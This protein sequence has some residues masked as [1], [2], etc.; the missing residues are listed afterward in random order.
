MIHHVSFGTSDLKRARKFYDPV[1]QVLGLRLLREDE[2]SIDY[3]AS[4]I[5]FSLEVPVNGRTSSPGN[6]VHIA[7][8]AEDRNMVDEFY[9][10]ALKHGGKDDGPPGLRPKYDANYYGAFV[11]DPDGN[12]VEA[13]T[14]SAR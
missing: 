12:K 10:T 14:F 6:G 4:Y 11:L 2:S 13:V 5:L 1:L 3:G 7:F 9:H 8:A